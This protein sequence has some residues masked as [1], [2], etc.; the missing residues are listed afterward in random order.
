MST[1]Q[2]QIEI[3]NAV[4]QLA[5]IRA[6]GQGLHLESLIAQWIQDYAQSPT[7]GVATQ[8]EIVTSTGG[9]QSPL[10]P[11]PPPAPEQ[12]VPVQPAPAP[13]QP[14]P[15]TPEPVAP[16]PSASIPNEHYNALSIASA[17]TDRP[18]HEHGDINLALRGYVPTTAH[19]GLIDLNGPTDGRAPQLSTIFANN[20]RSSVCSL[21]RTHH[22][23]WGRN[24]RGGQI[25]NYEVTVMGL[26]TNPAETVHLPRSGYHIG[27]GYN[28]LVL[29][30]DDERMT[31]KYTREDNVVHG[32]TL[33]VE[34]VAAEPRL[35][36]LYDQLNAAGRGQLPALRTGQAVGR[37]I[38]NEIRVAIRDAG[39]FMDPRVRKDW[40]A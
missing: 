5:Q 6:Q 2:I 11:V 16:D 18:A 30:V 23:D 4:Y 10:I 13:P 20:R 9:V 31:I 3:D 27:D 38:E 12:P 22:W 34:G 37:A 33:H 17:P 36:Q 29:F 25:T 28:A 39:S 14:E 7:I 21:F 24:A 32:Y 40:W 26:H 35:R 19:M 15:V 8:P 1:K